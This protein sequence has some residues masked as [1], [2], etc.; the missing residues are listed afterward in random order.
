MKIEVETLSPFQKRI[1]VEIAA[2]VVDQAIEK[3]FNDVQQHANLR[4]FRKGKAPRRLLEQMFKS[5]IEGSVIGQLIND[6]YPAAL[7]QNG[8]S[9]LTQPVID[10]G[11]IVRGSA[12]RY[13][14]TIEVTPPIDLKTVT[15]FS[16]EVIRPEVSDQDVQQQIDQLRASQAQL[17]SP[18]TERAAKKG[19]FVTFDYETVVSGEAVSEASG[20]GA[21]LELGKE[22][23]FEEFDRALTG[24]SPGQTKTIHIA[25]PEVFSVAALRGKQADVK[26]ALHAIKERSLPLIN[27][28]FAKDL[29]YDSMID[30]SKQVRKRLLTAAESTTRENLREAIFKRLTDIHH[31]EIPPSLLSR[32]LDGMVEQTRRHLA[33]TRGIPMNVSSRQTDQLRRNLKEDA[34]RDVAARLII[35]AIA[36]Q[37]QIDVVESDIEKE[38][39]RITEETGDD[40]HRVQHAYQ[41]DESAKEALTSH[42]QLEKVLAWITERSAVRFVTAPSGS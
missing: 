16:F 3:M 30:L 10:E 26:L 14:A 28:E 34:A 6:S 41:T 17:A 22:T 35:E 2:D 1:T 38:L 25:Y 42:V 19:D 27:D 23:T 29:G 4:G 12:F 9:P 32:R 8:I 15:G 40:L 13:H 5:E 36:K 18:E 11:A 33:V 24:M 20:A 39:A 37:E 7:D 31:V 21:T